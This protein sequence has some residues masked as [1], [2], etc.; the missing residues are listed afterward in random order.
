MVSP[1]QSD[2]LRAA[3]SEIEGYVPVAATF[4]GMTGVQGAKVTLRMVVELLRERADGRPDTTRT[5]TAEELNTHEQRSPAGAS[6]SSTPAQDTET[7]P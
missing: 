3:A 1:A 4:K 5:A 6:T 7:K 2:A